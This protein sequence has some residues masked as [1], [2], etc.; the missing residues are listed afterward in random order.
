MP[1]RYERMRPHRQAL[2]DLLAYANV[3]VKEASKG[4]CSQTYLVNVK[5]GKIPL[6]NRI[7]QKLAEKYGVR[8][9]TLLP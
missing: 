4:V 5:D 6:S 2:L 9:D 3:T 8:P 7:R 1:N